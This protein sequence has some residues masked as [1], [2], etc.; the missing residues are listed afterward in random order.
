MIWL[1]LDEKKSCNYKI[2]KQEVEEIL[3]TEWNLIL[4]DAVKKQVKLINECE[5]NRLNSWN[6]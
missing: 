1:L 3:I 6:S 5:R 2:I 4:K